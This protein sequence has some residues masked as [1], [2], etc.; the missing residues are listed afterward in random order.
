MS[1]C[2]TA[3]SFYLDNMENGCHGCFKSLDSES[4]DA[5]DPAQFFVNMSN[6]EL[7]WLQERDCK[8]KLW[9]LVF[10]TDKLECKLCLKNK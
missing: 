10:S 6:C 1:K 8:P 9:G 4:A 2:F 5:V 3:P 7:A